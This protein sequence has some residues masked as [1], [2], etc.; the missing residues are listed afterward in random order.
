LDVSTAWTGEDEFA[1]AVGP[2]LAR[3]VELA[4]RLLRSDDLAWE[5]VQDS[6]LCLWKA[7]TR[8]SHLAPWLVSAVV[9]RTR[10]LRRTRRRRCD[11]EAQAPACFWSAPVAADPGRHA[12]QEA[13]TRVA[14]S[15]VLRL[16]PEQSAVFVLKEI[17]GADY[18]SIARALDVPLGTVRSRLHRARGALRARLAHLA[19]A[20]EH[21]SQPRHA[22]PRRARHIDGLIRE[23]WPPSAVVTGRP[24][25]RRGGSLDDHSCTLDSVANAR[26]VVAQLDPAFRRESGRRPLADR[27]GGRAHRADGVRA[28]GRTGSG[29]GPPHRHPAAL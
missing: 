18:E 19:P 29:H 9:N 22:P 3:L 27:C 10:H 20:H 21:R 25:R 5:A 2:H 14:A 7:P 6:L 1:S 12:E 11:N 28:E 26:A 4:R 13:F 15:A 23:S 8:P 17:S 16:P 24:P